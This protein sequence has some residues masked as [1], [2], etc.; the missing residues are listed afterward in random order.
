LCGALNC[1]LEDLAP[2]EETQHSE[3]YDLSDRDIETVKDYCE[4]VLAKDHR[5]SAK[6]SSYATIHDPQ[7]RY[8]LDQTD[9]L[10]YDF[11]DKGI[12]I[13][14]VEALVGGLTLCN[15]MNRLSDGQNEQG[16]PPNE[17]YKLSAKQFMDCVEK[18][19]LS[20]NFINRYAIFSKKNYKRGLIFQNWTLSVYVIGWRPGHEVPMHHHGNSLDAIRVVQGKMTHWQLSEKEARDQNIPFEGIEGWWEDERFEAVSKEYKPGDLILVDKRTAHKIK[21]SSDDALVTLHYRFGTPADDDRW[22][23][24][25]LTFGCDSAGQCRVLK[26]EAATSSIPSFV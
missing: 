12:D 10:I 3:V 19:N 6:I 18:V 5:S 21:N 7:L 9:K 2:E 13:P 20:Q 1:S 23:P 16:A 14:D 24:D 4:A 22:E 17:A 25:V 26:S 8:W 11:R 15:L